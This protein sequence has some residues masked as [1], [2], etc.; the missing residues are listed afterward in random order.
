M[1]IKISNIGKIK[2]ADV[3]INGITVIAGENNT[4]KSTVGKALYA[5]FNSF[6]DVAKKVEEE[7]IDSLQRSIFTFLQEI[8]GSNMGFPQVDGNALATKLNDIKNEINKE[9]IIQV[10]ADKLNLKTSV[11]ENNY[12]RLEPSI[13]NIL[14]VLSVANDNY[15]KI[16]VQKNFSE[17][18]NQQINNILEN[19]NGEIDLTIKQKVSSVKFD[20]NIVVFVNKQVDIFSD[21]IYLDDPFILDERPSHGF[22]ASF[23]NSNGK[24]YRHKDKLGDLIYKQVESNNLVDKIV[25]EERLQKIIDKVHSACR[26]RTFFKN[27]NDLM[28]QQDNMKTAFKVANLSTGLKTF[29]ILQTLLL[30]GAIKDGS[31]IILDEPEIHLHPEW[32][33]LFAEL[34]VMLQK[35]FNLHIL[36]NTHSPYFLNA[37]EVFSEKYA[38]G[39]RCEYYLA[40]NKQDES[41]VKCVTGNV[42]EIYA[43]LA[44]PLQRLENLRYADDE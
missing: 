27:N 17:E 41:Y 39:D 16:L 8:S 30:S 25:I 28:Y 35:E 42:E 43:K 10:L 44:R 9:K 4:G 22:L 38:I 3:A 23:F 14:R 36:L 1:R 2:E 37:I 33:L 7:R 15:L 6:V 34:I 31:L 32:Q 18:F 19:T 29:V 11:I 40:Y 21:A 20:D 12:S 5:I 13:N 26:G 24:F